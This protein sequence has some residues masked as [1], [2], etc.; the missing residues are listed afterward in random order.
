MKRLIA[1]VLLAIS[2]TAHADFVS[3]ASKE[4]FCQAW[5]GNGIYGANQ[6]IKGAAPVIKPITIEMLGAMI[7]HGLGDD[8]LYVLN[9]PEYTED[10]KEFI[11]ESVIN[12]YN[13]MNDI[14]KSN[15]APPPSEIFGSMLEQSCLNKQKI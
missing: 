1:A 10:E 8:A 14:L 15:K 6:R 3:D 11:I 2:F 9:N 4:E 7:E 13:A 5:T 12:G